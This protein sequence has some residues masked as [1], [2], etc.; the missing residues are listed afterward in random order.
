MRLNKLKSGKTSVGPQRW[1]MLAAY[2]GVATMSQM[3]WLNIASLA[4]HIQRIYRVDDFALSALLLCFPLLYIFLSLHAGA[5]IDR[6]GY[7]WAI[8]AGSI[9]SSLF[10]ILRVGEHGFGLLLVGQFGIALGQPYI[11]N[12]ITKLVQDWFEED[13]ITVATGIGTSGMLFG[14]G[15]GLGLTP[16]LDVRFGFGETMAIFSIASMVLTFAFFLAAKLIKKSADQPVKYVHQ[17][18]QIIDLLKNRDLIKLFAAWFFAF[19][20]FNAL[21][22]WLGPILEQKGISETI[23]GMVGAWIIAGGFAGSLVI[24][25]IAGKF[26]L[27]REFLLFSCFS[28]LVTLWPLC[29]SNSPI[30]LQCLGGAFGFFFLPGYA[31][32]LEVCE[33]IAGS[34]RTAPATSLLMLAGNAGA[35]SAI[36]L[37]PTVHSII[38]DWGSA[39]FVLLPFAVVAFVLSIFMPKQVFTNKSVRKYT[40]DQNDYLNNRIT[41]Q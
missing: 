38:N 4:P 19:G 9:I 37:V 25:A 39:M 35:V 23:S 6:K 12:G 14:M 1:Y 17:H 8:L 18:G 27:H 11:V 3:L 36:F 10:S 33:N 20:G 32:T 40:L 28:S 29:T 5:I 30:L 2:F 16:L 41:D 7:R 13:Q 15:I 21:S 22:T 24:P 26:K 34:E 31:L